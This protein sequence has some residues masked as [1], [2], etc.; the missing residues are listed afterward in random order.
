MLLT[1]IRA[2]LQEWIAFI[3]FHKEKEALEKKKV[4]D[5]KVKI[6]FFKDGLVW[7]RN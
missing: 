3:E 1:D 4:I 2:I 5:D 7:F 6:S